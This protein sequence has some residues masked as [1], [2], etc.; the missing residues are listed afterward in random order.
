MA[1]ARCRALELIED[2]AFS[3]LANAIG[4]RRDEELMFRRDAL[5]T[6]CPRPRG[7]AGEA[8]RL[9]DR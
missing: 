3:S 2:D 6:R 8:N 5:S 1:S 9:N 4:T 7:S